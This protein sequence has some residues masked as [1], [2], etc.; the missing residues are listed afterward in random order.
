MKVI[1]E[2]QVMRAYVADTHDREGKAAK[3][4]RV[5]L[6]DGEELLRVT[7]VP[8]LDSFIPGEVATLRV[9]VYSGD[10]GLTLVYDSQIE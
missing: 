9:K 6:Y 2:G 10:R 5:D 8:S 7:R 4:N 3:V 1:I